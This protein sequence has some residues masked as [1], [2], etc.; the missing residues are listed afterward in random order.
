MLQDEKE[1]LQRQFNDKRDLME[2][3][4]RVENEDRLHA[5]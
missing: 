4:L 3:R 5:V 2:K 1:K